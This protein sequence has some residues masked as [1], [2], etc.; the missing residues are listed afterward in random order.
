MPSLRP[1][2]VAA[3]A[4]GTAAPAAALEPLECPAV[5]FLYDDN[6]RVSEKQTDTNGDCQPDEFVFYVDGIAMRGETDRNHDGKVDAWA[7][8]GTD[9]SFVRQQFDETGDGRPDRTISFA[10]QHPSHRE[11]DRNG[12]GHSDL[13][14]TFEGGVPATS[15]EDTN[16]DRHM[17]RWTWFARSS[18][19][20][21]RRSAS[22][23][24]R[25]A[26]ASST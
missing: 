12:D 20:T 6:E 11:E 15:E 8:F 13:F 5:V 1:I 26:T 7:E 14:I 19:R 24:T 22:S 9:G 25:R 17:D 3:L 4:L 10:G 2:L 21:E 23:R 18:T 16:F